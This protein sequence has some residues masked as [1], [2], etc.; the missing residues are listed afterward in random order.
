MTTT[1]KFSFVL[2]IFVVYMYLIM[3]D[4]LVFCAVSAILQP[5]QRTIDNAN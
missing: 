5:R 4:Y 2:L 3:I 1:S